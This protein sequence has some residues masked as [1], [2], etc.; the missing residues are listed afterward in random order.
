MSSKFIEILLEAKKKKT[1]EGDLDSPS[2]SSKNKP[3]TNDD[4]INDLDQEDYTE[5]IEEIGPDDEDNTTDPDDIADDDGSIVDDMKNDNEDN[6][7]LEQQNDNENDNTVQ[8]D[9]ESNSEDVGDETA[10]TGEGETTD[11]TNMDG[12]TPPEEGE[13]TSSNDEIDT[14]TEEEPNSDSEQENNDGN[15]NKLS[16]I[17]DFVNLYNFTD[18]FIEK[19]EMKID[20]N[21]LNQ[22]IINQ[23]KR[24]LMKLK[25]YVYNY[26]MFDYDNDTYIN[27]LTIYNYFVEALKIN[28]EMLTYIT[29]AISDKEQNNKK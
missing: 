12:E 26:I 10:D 19:L 1:D 2:V 8:D 20:I 9:V 28:S 27:N 7:S 13:E 29:K 18:N 25:D 23:I 22:Q 5:D 24:N 16:L 21:I 3:L 17:S 4:E 6:N 14:N 15:R 11:Y